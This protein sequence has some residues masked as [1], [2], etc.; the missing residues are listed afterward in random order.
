MRGS[1]ENRLGWA[2]EK[3]EKSEK[4]ESKMNAPLSQVVVLKTN[5]LLSSK[6]RKKYT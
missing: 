6:T 3:A 2:G 1:A 5:Q 4:E